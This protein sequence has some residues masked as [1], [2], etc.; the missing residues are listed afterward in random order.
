[1]ILTE[2]LHTV[3]N[4]LRPKSE[5]TSTQWTEAPPK[6]QRIL[7]ARTKQKF[8][9]A[10]SKV[11][12]FGNNNFR[13]TKRSSAGKI[14]FCE[15]TVTKR[16][17]ATK[18]PKRPSLTQLRM[19]LLP[20]QREKHYRKGTSMLLTEFLTPSKLL[21]TNDVS[22]KGKSNKQESCA[23]LDHQKKPKKRIKK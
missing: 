8:N 1:M 14:R 21:K 19:L 23:V 5:A 3:M 18:A 9:G 7:R 12:H 2:R 22:S 11:T 13:G 20:I 15:V 16:F 6:Q 4:L 17:D 10:A